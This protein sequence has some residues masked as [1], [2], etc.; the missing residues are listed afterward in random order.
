MPAAAR[1][2]DISMCPSDSH[3]NICCSHGVKGPA[4]SGSGNVIVVGQGQLRAAGA[5]NG[6]HS[7][8]CGPNTWV[9]VQ[10]SGTVFIN[11]LPAVRVGDTTK[12]CGGSGSVVTGADNVN[13]GG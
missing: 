10:G 1:Q 11:D 9:T 4:V 13:I 12:H 8:C 6:V 7:G 2:T 3:G 5:D